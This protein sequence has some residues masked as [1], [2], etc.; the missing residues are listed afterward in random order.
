MKI[1]HV[2]MGAVL[3]IVGIGLTAAPAAAANAQPTSIAPLAGA[4][5][6][7]KNAGTGM[8]LEPEGPAEFTRIRQ[9]PCDRANPAQGWLEQRVGT[10]HYMF[11]NQHTGLC[12]DA[13]DGAVNGGRLL[14]SG[15]FRGL[16]TEEFN[17]DVDL[18]NITIIE[19]R[20]HGRDTGFCVDVPGGQA[21]PGLLMQIFRCN[22]TPAQRWVIGFDI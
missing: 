20:V 11:L 6:P 5:H 15:C 14:Q 7:I 17:T 3:A 22:G 9:M 1:R 4:F 18:P 21:T 10:H 12:F 16:S 8:C 19:S 2:L 13:F